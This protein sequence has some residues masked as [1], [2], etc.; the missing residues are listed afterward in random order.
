MIS[1]ELKHNIALYYFFM[2]VSIIQIYIYFHLFNL[3]V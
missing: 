3:I 1:L 2:K